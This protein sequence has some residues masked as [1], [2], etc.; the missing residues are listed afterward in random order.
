MLRSACAQPPISPTHSYVRMHQQQ[1][2]LFCL[3]TLEMYVGY[4]QAYMYLAKIA[5]HI[6]RSLHMQHGAGRTRCKEVVGRENITCSGVH[7]KSWGRRHRM[8]VG[9]PAKEKFAHIWVAGHAARCA[10][11]PPN[12]QLCSCV[13]RSLCGSCHSFGVKCAVCVESGR[14]VKGRRRRMQQPP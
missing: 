6:V 4:V 10:S 14:C 2:A 11:A 7:H 8:Q 5:V 1:Q 9:S 3:P 12:L 13:H